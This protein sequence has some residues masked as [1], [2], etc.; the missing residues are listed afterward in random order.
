MTGMVLLVGDEQIE[1]HPG[2]HEWWRHASDI[3]EKHRSTERLSLT[4]QID[5]QSKLS[6]QLP[7]APFRVVYNKSGMHICAAKLRNKKALLTTGLYW[8]PLISEQ[9]ADYLCAILNAPITT[10]LAR[11]LMS[12]GKDERDI[13]KHVWELPIQQF[14]PHNAV[15]Q[16][17]ATLGATLEKLASTFKID[18]KLHFAATRRHIRDFTMDT[19][20]GQELNGLVSDMLE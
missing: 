12:Y 13:H 4:Q 17:I 5:F 9:E 2:L 14:D 1:L 6:K 15:H 19:A 3:W 8:A 18:E 20:E 11:P 10:E 7:I 16:R